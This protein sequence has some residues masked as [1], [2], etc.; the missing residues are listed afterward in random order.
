MSPAALE[1]PEYHMKH[2]IKGNTMKIAIPIKLPLYST[3]IIIATYFCGCASDDTTDVK[4]VNSQLKGFRE[5][6]RQEDIKTSKE[7]E[8]DLDDELNP[9]EQK[10]IHSIFENNLKSK[11]R[12]DNDMFGD[13]PE[14][15]QK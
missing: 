12:M 3:L 4:K 14:Q 5:E 2:R 15:K 11:Q 1:Y 10:A 6:I 7:M 9:V 8:A 13:L